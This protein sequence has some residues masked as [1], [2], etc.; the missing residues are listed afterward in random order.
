MAL[1]L[2]KAQI[3][4]FCRNIP[5]LVS[6]TWDELSAIDGRIDVLSTAISNLNTENDTEYMQVRVPADAAAG[7]TFERAIFKAPSDGTI[8][9][10]VVVPDSDIG[11]ATN[12]MTLDVQNKGADGTGTDSIGSRAVN[13]TNTIEGMVG[14]D[15]VST[16]ADIDAGEV[17]SLKKTV[18]ADGQVWPGGMVQ[19][20]F[21]R[22]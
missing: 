22:D 2:S 13:S 7:D 10:V 5:G 15:L 18:T 3:T 12:F 14:V 19:V 21:T 9:D 8:V 1:L 6:R 20:K 16:S 4:H 17:L 11:Q